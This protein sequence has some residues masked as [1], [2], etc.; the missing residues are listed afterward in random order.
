MSAD[1]VG[2]ACC[3]N[4]PSLVPRVPAPA[5]H[6]GAITMMDETHRRSISSAG[7]HVLEGV[8]STPARG[9]SGR[10]RIVDQQGQVHVFSLGPL[11]TKT[12]QSTVVAVPHH[13]VEWTVAATVAAAEVDL[14]LADLRLRAI[15]R[16]AAFKHMLRAIGCSGGRPNPWR[17]VV[18]VS[19]LVVPL[20]LGQ[21]RAA[22]DR[23]VRIYQGG[24]NA[25]R[26]VALP[27]CAVRTGPL[28]RFP[29]HWQPEHQLEP[30]T[31]EGG[32]EEW[33][34][35]GDDPQFVL[36]HRRL[37]LALPPGWYELNL[38]IITTAGRLLG[39]ALYP[40]YGS[41]WTPHD[42]VQLAAA[43][44]HGR[45]RDLIM[46]RSAVRGLRLDPS[47]RRLQFQMGP[48]QLRR[49]GRARALARLLELSVRKDGSR[50]WR[51]LARSA[52]SF[53][54]DA[55]RHGLTAAAT[56]LY[57]RSRPGSGGTEMD[58]ADWVRLYDTQS[59]ADR[60][61]LEERARELGDGPLI[62]ILLPVY[63]TPEHWLK[64][65]LDS[66]RTQVYGN[67]E[68]CVVDDASPSPHVLRVL[69]DYARRDPRI[70][71]TRR[72][73][74]GHISR[75]S[76]TALEMARGKYVAL[77]DHDDELRPHALLEMAEAVARN[78]GVGLLYSDEDKI[79]EEGHRF[80]P[81]FKPDWNPDLLLSQ[82]FM[83]HLA[84][85]DT[86]LARD[87]GG[88]RAGF[89]GS[90][91]HDLFLRC[92]A[93]LEHW[94]IHHVPKV[95]YHWRAIAGSTALERSAKDYASSAGARAVQAQ[96]ALA[97]PGAAVEELPHGH[98]RVRWPLP[99][100]A[101]KVS[102]IVPT[103]DRADLLR[104]CIESL[105]ELTVYPDY[106]V[107]VVDNQ[108]RDPEA[109][110]YLASLSGREPTRVLGFD[111]PFN[112]SAINNWAVAE[113]RGEVVCLLNN[114][115]EVISPDWLE[116]LVSQALRPGVGAVGAML[117]YP[118]RTIQHAGVVLGLGGVAN[119]AYTGQPAGHPGHGARA[120][121]AQNL[122]AVTGACL[123]VRR[124]LYEQ[125]GGLD[126]RLQVAFNDVDFCL[127]LREAGYRNVWTPFAELIHH[128]SASR[129]RDDSPE[130]RERFLGE[131]RYMESRWDNWL[132]DDPAYNRN[133]SLADLSSGLAFPPR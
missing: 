73:E 102:I 64:L 103:R 120:L 14:P 51:A 11:S 121:V 84:V 1:F 21:V 8:C 67:W 56:H 72:T 60:L 75:A 108:S 16:F 12:P 20:C 39:P 65:C 2:A 45:S 106:E 90:Q 50:D 59:Q 123:V 43:D 115:I 70:R 126:E 94:Q 87:A 128:E 7:W 28:R 25:P 44:E 109:L 105:L 81:Y 37:P 125:L 88:F 68:L 92:T 101:P 6:F 38:Q 24:L 4:L 36:V 47:L 99:A 22:G 66:V 9:A 5:R 119:H 54:M 41:G 91:D 133:L 130:K 76:N 118:D 132:Q 129:G 131:V 86:Q 58:Y 55:M 82:N 93:R 26:E 61:M 111:A 62:S 46:F 30:V 42:V 15:S 85:I 114:D 17:M 100:V 107:L 117:Y 13:A 32:Q 10:L 35:G 29:A 63:Q 57:G 69:D 3:S 18:A 74:N 83:C 19:Q 31:G 79:D 110:E 27:A 34:A 40:D 112:Y 49:I 78:P 97:A 96:L 98:Y 48:S 104:T 89:E 95:L 77:L 52:Q 122:S 53:G 127:R 116:E 113:C 80:H 71:V 33:A 124:A 23:L